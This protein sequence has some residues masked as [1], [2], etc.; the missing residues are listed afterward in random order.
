M[1]KISYTGDGATKEF[2]FSF[3]FFQEDD[4]RA[5]INENILAP[6]QYGVNANAEYDG[7]TVEF[8]D[9]PADGAKIEIFRRISLSR[10][11]D[12][13]PAGRIYP[14]DL[15]TDFN[16]LLEAFRDLQA[17]D[18]DLAEWQNIHDNV[19]SFIE[20]TKN[21]IEDKLSGGGVLGLYNNLLSVLDGALP[22]LINDYGSVAEPANN[23]NSD[24]YGIL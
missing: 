20:Y 6:A 2:V 1:H 22:L 7:G 19:L 12:Y 10:V 18:I 13:Q 16:F 24:D 17:V 11:V 5:A 21:L 4:V 9:A 15:N 8:A 14:E 23:E 3:P